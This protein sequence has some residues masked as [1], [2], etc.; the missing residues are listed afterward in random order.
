MEKEEKY[1]IRTEGFIGDSFIWWRPNSQG[2]TSDLNKAGKYKKEE[3][4]QIC[5]ASETEAAYECTKLDNH[6]TAIFRTANAN[7]LSYK[8]ADI[9]FRK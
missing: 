1:Y 5:R 8:D 6:P 4:E 9:N 3:A 7:Y 2:Y